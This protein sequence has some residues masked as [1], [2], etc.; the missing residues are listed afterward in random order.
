MLQDAES[1]RKAITAAV[2]AFARASSAVQAQPRWR[3]T[4]L[5]LLTDPTSGDAEPLS[6]SPVDTL[7]V[8]AEEEEGGSGGLGLSAASLFAEEGDEDDEE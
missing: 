2:Q 3:I 7:G 5:D 4:W 8:V 6:G 1:A